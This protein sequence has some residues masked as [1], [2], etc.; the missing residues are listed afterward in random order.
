MVRPKVAAVVGVVEL[1]A[2]ELDAPGADG[3]VAA[4]V[5]EEPADS[6][7]TAALILE[8]AV[9]YIEEPASKSLFSARLLYFKCF[10]P[11]LWSAQCSG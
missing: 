6:P 10:L 1:V 9:E 2:P 11:M 8:E 3:S 7:G 5:L 4:P